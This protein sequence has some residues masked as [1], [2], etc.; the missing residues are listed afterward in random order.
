MLFTFPLAKIVPQGLKATRMTTLM[1][2]INPR[3]TTKSSFSAG[4]KSPG[5]AQPKLFV[6]PSTAKGLP[7][8]NS[9]LHKF[10]NSGAG[11]E[12]PAYSETEFQRHTRL[13]A[14]DPDSSFQ[15][16]LHHEISKRA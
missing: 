9:Q 3:P 10:R 13:K 15:R 6:D 11:D 12:S 5:L 4:C 1:P 14:S 7:P 2:G 8:A 16:N